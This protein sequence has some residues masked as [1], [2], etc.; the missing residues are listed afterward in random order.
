LRFSRHI[1]KESPW[2]E[3]SFINTSMLFSI[4]LEKM[5]SIQLWKVVGALHSPK[6]IF[7]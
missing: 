7:L 4:R 2:T 1:T 3:K 6:G 5:A